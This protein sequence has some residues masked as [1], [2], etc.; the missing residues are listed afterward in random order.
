MTTIG[1]SFMLAARG[2]FF[3]A[4]DPRFREFALAGSRSAGRYSRADDP[5]HYLGLPVEEINASMLAH[6]G[7]RQRN[8]EIDV[9]ASR[10]VCS[11]GS[12]ASGPPNA[13]GANTGAE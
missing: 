12:G 3:R 10:I 2:T 8:V 13:P 6:K 4:V 7:V 11:R 5:T 1:S 9:E